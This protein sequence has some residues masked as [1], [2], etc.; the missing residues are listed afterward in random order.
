[1]AATYTL[2]VDVGTTCVT[3]AVARRAHDGSATVA[4]VPIGRRSDHMPAL[5]F[6]AEGGDVHFGEVAARRG[7]LEPERLIREARR[8]VGDD[9]PLLVGGY[10]IPAE[11]LFARTVASVV[12]AVTAH[13]Q[14]APAGIGV[15]YPATWGP[16]RLGLVRSAL[17]GVGL[18]SIELIAEPQAAAHQL[19]AEDPFDSGQVLVVYDLGGAT[20][21]SAVLRKEPEGTWTILGTAQE[22][23]DLGGADFDDVV[24][25]HVLASAGLDELDQGVEDVRRDL[26]QLRR[27]CIDAKEALSVDPDV[28]IPVIVSGGHTTVRLTRS[29]FEDMIEEAIDRTCDVLDDT[30]DGA[31][32]SVE[33]VEA[34][35]LTGGAARTP[36]VAQRLSELFDRPIEADVDPQTVIALGAARAALV[37]LEESAGAP[38]GAL[39]LREPEPTEVARPDGDGATAADDGS[40]DVPHGDL[41]LAAAVGASSARPKWSLMRSMGTM[42]AVAAVMVGGSLSVSLTGML[43]D[44]EDDER[45][46]ARG[47]AASDRTLTEALRGGAAAPSSDPFGLASTLGGPAGVSEQ[48]LAAALPGSAST[49]PLLAGASAVG[50]ATPVKASATATGTTTTTTNTLAGTTTVAAPATTPTVKASATA[51]GTTTTKPST[52]ASTPPPAQTQAPSPVTQNPTTQAPPPV[53]QNPTTQ[54]PPPVTQNPT[55]EAPPPVTEAPPAEQPA[56]PAEQPAP[57]PQSEAPAPASASTPTPELAPELTP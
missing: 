15:T 51:T 22:I 40:G 3:A 46:S 11:Q 38:A 44:V 29:E 53:T 8:S 26:T 10:Q 1:M 6:V 45:V 27:E 37:R 56:P 50:A 52:P 54:A 4:H 19:E 41:A 31:G 2:G 7:R 18:D 39:A 30:M 16:H 24:L 57:P 23:C 36:R 49:A 34:I 25:R 55:T 9:V 21:E 5:A 28:T 20:F 13:E 48:A 35:L 17:A 32:V 14:A 33:E 47:V 42:A 12:E 43:R